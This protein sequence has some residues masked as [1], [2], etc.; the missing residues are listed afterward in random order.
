MKLSKSN[1]WGKIV[2]KKSALSLFALGLPILFLFN[3]MTWVKPSSFGVSDVLVEMEE[4]IG[5][6]RKVANGVFG[7][8]GKN[9]IALHMRHI[10]QKI[11]IKKKIKNCADLNKVIP[12]MT[13]TYGF[14]RHSRKSKITFQKCV[15][16]GVMVSLIN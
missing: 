3:N 12:A 14:H 1:K 15:N 6:N 7:H 11:I 13:G 2:S 5:L 8:K 16:N 9:I 10:A 4:Y